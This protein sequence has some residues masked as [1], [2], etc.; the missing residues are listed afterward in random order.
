[1]FFQIRKN[2]KKTFFLTEGAQNMKKQEKV[3][4]RP[5]SYIRP[6]FLR[7]FLFKNFVFLEKYIKRLGKSVL[8]RRKIVILRKTPYLI[9][10]SK[11]I[12]L[13]NFQKYFVNLKIQSHENRVYEWLMH[14]LHIIFN[15]PI[16]IM[17]KTF[18][19]SFILKM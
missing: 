16:C 15:F 9:T 7:D 18:K 14:K 10:Y 5:F 3:G 13:L 17:F 8:I 6:F 11:L 4:F 2:K 19:S 12:R 1:M